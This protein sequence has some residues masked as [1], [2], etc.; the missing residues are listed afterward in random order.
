MGRAM[1]EK[2]VIPQGASAPER[3]HWIA[4]ASAEHVRIGRGAGFMQVGHGKSAP[5]RRIHPGDCIVYYSPAA[6]MGEADG[7]Q[8]FTAIGVVRSGEPYQADMGGAFQPWRR[9]VA[10][11]RAQETAIR[12]LLEE[13]EFT[14]GRRNWGYQLRFGLFAISAHDFAV[15]AEALRARLPK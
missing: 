14:A 1:A 7:L 11:A 12:P 5:L 2:I 4:V 9:D 3:S 6:V 10:W 8:S 13:L 15:I